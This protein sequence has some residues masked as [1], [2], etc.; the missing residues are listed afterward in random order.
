MLPRAVGPIAGKMVG[1]RH[2]GDHVDDIADGRPVL[3]VGRDVVAARL[4][5][6][7]RADV[8][9]VFVQD[10]RGVHQ[11]ALDG[12]CLC[13]AVFVAEVDI[14]GG[15]IL[16]GV[17]RETDIVELDLVEAHGLHRVDGQRDLVFPYVAAEGAGPVAG[18]D[19]QR[20]AGAVGD[21]VFGMILAEEGVVEGRQTAD[22]VEARVL[23]LLNDRLVFCDGVIRVLIRRGGILL[24]YRRIVADGRAVHDVDNEGV[25]LRGL[26]IFNVLVD[27]L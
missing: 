26:R 25:D 10:I 11:K 23:D 24:V 9:A 20:V 19:I 13:L 6:D 8:D 17:V 1:V 16:V 27:V 21:G 14:A 18:R 2:T 15:L 3:A 12:L 5:E 7:V 22:G 4:A